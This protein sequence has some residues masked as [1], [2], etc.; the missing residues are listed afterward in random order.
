MV[1]LFLRFQLK[2]F[3]LLLCIAVLIAGIG[4]VKVEMT[5]AF[6]V[7]ALDVSGFACILLGCLSLL[8]SFASRGSFEVQF[9]RSVGAENLEARMAR[10]VKDMLGSFYYLI[11][12]VWTG[13]LQLLL[14]ALIHRTAL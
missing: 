8:G 7:R 6:F 11:L 9:S 12:F 14:S 2:C 13:A 4:L 3:L 5:A 10:D 1:G